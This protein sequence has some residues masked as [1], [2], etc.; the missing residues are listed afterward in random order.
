MYRLLLAL[1]RRLALS[2][3]TQM[4]VLRMVNDEFLVG[5]TGVIFNADHEVLV[6]KHSYRRVPWSLPGGFLKGGEHPKK[7]LEREVYEE[8]HFK[9]HIE[10]LIKTQHDTDGARLDFCYSGTYKKGKFK[11]SHEV[12]DYGFFS[13]SKLP[14]LIDDQY[15]QIEL[16]YD[17]YKK[18]HTL[19][20]MKRIRNLLGKTLMK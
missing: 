7:G 20:F 16:A 18:S 17:Q 5:V 1:W 13:R 10:K 14:P 15:K 8:T 2:K 6:V 19:P 4:R 9:V 3:N 12:V 11:K